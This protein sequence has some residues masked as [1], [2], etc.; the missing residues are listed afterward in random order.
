MG[1]LVRRAVNI[2]LIM[3]LAG[4]TILFVPLP[5]SIDQVAAQPT[6]PL[7]AALSVALRYSLTE[8]GTPARVRL[9][10]ARLMALQ[11]GP[12][13]SL[14]R[15]VEPL[16]MTARLAVFTSVTQSE[17]HV[18]QFYLPRCWTQGLEGLTVP[19]A[20]YLAARMA[21]PARTDE[22]FIRDGMARIAERAQAADEELAAPF[23]A[24]TAGPLPVCD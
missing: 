5:V 8:R 15:L 1:W 22:T 9:Q 18:A 21:A 17:R 16:F 2:V 14:M 24:A 4:A 20:L 23:L 3:G 11:G 10:A 13:N 7:P 12:R 6:T 19:K